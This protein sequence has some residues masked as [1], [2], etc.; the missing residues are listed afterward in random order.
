MQTTNA[1]NEMVL[2]DG[3]L[4]PS[5]QVP[6]T[7]DQVTRGQINNGHD[8][9][10]TEEAVNAH[11]F[12]KV[13]D[14]EWEPVDAPVFVNGRQVPGV[15]AVTRSDTGNVLGINGDG[16]ESV[17]NTEMF[18]LADALIGEDPSLKRGQAGVFRGGKRVFLQ[19]SGG[20][21]EVNGFEVERFATLFNSFDGTLNFIAGFSN[22]FIVCR[23]TYAMAMRGA[24]N[25][26]KLK[27]T[28]G[29][30]SKVVEA[31]KVLEAASEYTA[32]FDNTVLALAVKPFSDLNMAQLAHKLIPGD[33]TRS[34]NSRAD[35][36]RAW[37]G[38]PGA[39]PG[40]ALGAMQ[41][42]TYYGSHKVGIRETEGR[43]TLE[44]RRE[45]TWWGAGS[46]LSEGAWWVVTDPEATEILAAQTV[47]V[48]LT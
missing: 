34:E 7:E 45:S 18:D 42:V 38:A 35:L 2:V 40:T 46:K 27:H 29:V 17:G 28:A 19:I 43:S 13:A 5:T 44:A 10:V 20:R 47:T 4:V 25:G 33:S 24:G 16:Y 39:R 8:T 36:M 21:R 9:V 1:R 31:R 23:N 32:E 3:E 37:H 30:N 14:L 11:S 15:K 22:V 12:R 26:I 6:L 48:A 41:A